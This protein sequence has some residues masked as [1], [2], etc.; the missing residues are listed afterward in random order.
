MLE[1]APREA[2]GKW[3][4]MQNEKIATEEK[5]HWKSFIKNPPAVYQMVLFRGFD[6]DGFV[7]MNVRSGFTYKN[8]VY[9]QDEGHRMVKLSEN[10]HEELEWM[11]IPE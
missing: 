11:E 4:S 3:R 1:T 10:F 2:L 5:S 6:Y 8:L 7:N 9:L